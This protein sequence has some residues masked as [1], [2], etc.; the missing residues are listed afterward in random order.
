MP[1]K[2]ETRKV[3]AKKVETIA[4]PEF[5]RSSLV[6]VLYAGTL[7]SPTTQVLRA[8]EAQGAVTGWVN[9][10]GH[11]FPSM[12]AWVHQR[13]RALGWP[14]SN[15]IPTGYYLFVDGEVRA[16]HP[17]L[18]DFQNDKLS[19]GIGALFALGTLFTKT[20]KT[21]WDA[22]DIAHAEASQRVISFFTPI[23]E[24]FKAYAA[25]AHEI[26]S[27]P[28]LPPPLVD[29]LTQAFSVLRL[30]QSAT[31]ADVKQRRMD[32]VKQW[33][34]DQ[35]ATDPIA[36]AHANTVLTQINT[37]YDLILVRRGWS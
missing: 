29:E 22:F 33:H 28:P 5:I 4:V 7:P 16:F 36:F 27:A 21:L 34:P 30:D 11:M 8:F 37:A 18:V 13:Q 23:A 19:V 24:T 10:D 17:G 20:S 31:L 25:R 12:W 26:P 2:I 9:T 14:P 15:L 1:K 6:V 35:F 32:L 3:D